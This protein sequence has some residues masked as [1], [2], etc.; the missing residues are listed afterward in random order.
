VCGAEAAW[1]FEV[2]VDGG[3][4]VHVISVIDVAR[5]DGD[6]RIVHNRAFWDRSTARSEAKGDGVPTHG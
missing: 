1:A 2:H 3:T 4:V 5:F 6:G